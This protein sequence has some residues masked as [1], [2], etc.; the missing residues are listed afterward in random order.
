M[1][2][3][4]N[5]DFD[6]D[7]IISSG[8]CFRPCAISES[9]KI[10][11]FIY[12]QH[13][14]YITNEDQNIY[15][16]SCNMNEWNEIWSVYFD[17][18]RDYEGIRNDIPCDDTYMYE[19]SIDGKGIRILKQDKWEMLISFIIS[20]RKSIPAIRSCI[21][22]LC[23][24]YGSKISTKKEDVY[25][26]PTAE[27]MINADENE[28]ALCGLGYRIGYILDAVKKV[29][30]KEIDL[31]RIEKL[32]DDDLFSELTSIKGVGKKVANCI[33]L[34]AYNRTAR[35]PVD[36]WIARVIDEFYNGNDP[37]V[38]YG[39]NAGIMQQYVFYHIQNRHR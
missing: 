23:L 1:K 25:L 24:K 20:Q 39:E 12:R 30:Y 21:E 22:K 15:D 35:A 38:A 19:S 28:L 3:T 17:L 10:Y 2:I 36:V 27:Q 11:R 6:L 33:M 8:Q 13:V 37:F 32:S 9:P 31:D 14:L 29:Y 16:V 18:K 34:F 7:K 4:I 5:D 26:F